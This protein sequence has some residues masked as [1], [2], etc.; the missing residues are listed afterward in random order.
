MALGLDRDIQQASQSVTAI[1]RP[2]RSKMPNNPRS[3][4]LQSPG[5]IPQ[6]TENE[7]RH[8]KN[9]KK[10]PKTTKNK[11]KQKPTGGQSKRSRVTESNASQIRMCVPHRRPA[12]FVHS[13]CTKYTFLFATD[14]HIHLGSSIPCSGMWHGD[15]D[16]GIRKPWQTGLPRDHASGMAS[17]QYST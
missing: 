5:K 3:E 14:I 6:H 10:E 9:K 16:D 12:S 13:L 2:T 1:S 11:R 4:S 7:N 15:M 8:K 17:G